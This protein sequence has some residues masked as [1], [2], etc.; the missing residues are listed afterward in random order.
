MFEVLFFV[1]STLIGI[2]IFEDVVVPATIQAVDLVKP[3]VDQ[4]VNFVNPT[5]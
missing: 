1:V 2:G 4:A 3:V 5:E